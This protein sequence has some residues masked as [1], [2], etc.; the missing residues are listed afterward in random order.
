M[1]LLDHIIPHSHKDAAHEAVLMVA[2]SLARLEKKLQD[3]AVA[4]VGTRSVHAAEK[5]C[6]RAQALGKTMEKFAGALAARLDKEKAAH[7]TN[8]AS[9]QM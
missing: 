5:L 7:D 4:K 9:Q 3:L 6:K 8:K 1:Q 2:R